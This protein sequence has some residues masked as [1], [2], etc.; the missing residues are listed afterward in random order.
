MVDSFCCHPGLVQE[1][2]AN[3]SAERITT[4]AATT[5]LRAVCPRCVEKTAE[6]NL[7][8]GTD[9]LLSRLVGATD[10]A[11]LRDGVSAGST[12][13]RLAQYKTRSNHLRADRQATFRAKL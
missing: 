13:G 7:F 8:A 6:A 12:P 2:S 4:R 9:F 10:A 5:G 11:T 1:N 3:A